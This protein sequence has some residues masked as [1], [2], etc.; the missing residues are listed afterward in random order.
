MFLARASRDVTCTYKKQT[1]AIC[2][3][4]DRFEKA[5]EKLLAFDQLVGVAT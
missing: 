5:H 3:T 1:A 2:R 4:L